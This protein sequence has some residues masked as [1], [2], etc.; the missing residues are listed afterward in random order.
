MPEQGGIVGRNGADGWK[1][2]DVD[3]NGMRVGE[4]GWRGKVTVF[5]GTAARMGRGYGEVVRSSRA[6]GPSGNTG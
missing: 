6:V 3:E 1:W 2:W 5:R 4:N